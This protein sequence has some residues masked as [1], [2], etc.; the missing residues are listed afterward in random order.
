MKL[1]Q[2][3]LYPVLLYFTERII[4]SGPKA[5]PQLLHIKCKA[6]LAALHLFLELTE[7]IISICAFSSDD[8]DF[9]SR[10]KA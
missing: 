2:L 1:S 4:S 5:F 3:M 7:V 10:V 8:S 9:F 6:L